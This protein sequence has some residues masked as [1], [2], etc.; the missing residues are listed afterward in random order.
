M[1]HSYDLRAEVAN[2]WSTL[3]ATSAHTPDDADLDRFVHRAVDDWRTCGCPPPVVALLEYAEKITKAPAELCEAVVRNLRRQGWSDE[4]IH[5]AV[6]VVAYFNYINRVAD[7]LGVVP[8]GF[9]PRWG[10]T[11]W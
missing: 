11:Q 10:K 7:A 2:D 4:A 5:D 1:A 6:Q 9:I 3:A 8:E